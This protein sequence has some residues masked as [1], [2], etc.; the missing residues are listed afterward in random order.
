[1][2]AI[3]AA[4]VALSRLVA[5]LRRRV[6]SLR[7]WLR[8][9]ARDAWIVANVLVLSVALIALFLYIPGFRPYVIALVA[10]IGAIFTAMPGLVSDT[11]F[12]RVT[13]AF[14]CALFVGAGTWYT[15]V[16][17]DRAKALLQRQLD[18]RT[19]QLDVLHTTF[20][21]SIGRTAEHRS[22]SIEDLANLLQ[23]E[24]AAGRYEDVL[25]LTSWLSEISP[26][27]GHTLYYAGE[28]YRVQDNLEDMRGSFKRYLAKSDAIADSRIGTAADCYKRANGFCGERTAWIEHMM[29][30]DTYTSALSMRN[31]VEQAREMARAWR[32]AHDALAIR[33]PFEA[34]T[35]FDATDVVQ[36][37]AALAYERLTNRKISEQTGSID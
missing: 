27:N 36:A 1:M 22:E 20:I 10:S 14:V 23:T 18:V 19:R 5:R 28:V 4:V 30:N 7:S 21:K 9:N 17:Q 6:T 3:D 15:A 26:E 8:K 11:P 12:V 25:Q 31:R 29:A 35:S 2:Q 24:W 33:A 32:F 13:T 16:D 37:N 34:T